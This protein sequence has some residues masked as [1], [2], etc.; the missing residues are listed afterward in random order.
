[1][2]AYISL[3]SENE[4]A[5]DGWEDDSSS[6]SKEETE[7]SLLMLDVEESSVESESLAERGMR[8]SIDTSCRYFESRARLKEQSTSSNSSSSLRRSGICG[9]IVTR[10]RLR[11]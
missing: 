3:M 10:E 7:L 9:M 1:M 8:A 2:I 6:E 11:R 5:R 4:S